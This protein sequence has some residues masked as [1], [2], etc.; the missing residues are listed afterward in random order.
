MNQWVRLLALIGLAACGIVILLLG[1]TRH[2]ADLTAPLNLVLFF[3]GVL[4]YLLPTGLAY[5]RDCKS[6]AWIATV[7]VLLGW[8][9]FGWFVA[10]GWAA[11]G[12]TREP[13]HQIGAPPNHPVPG[14]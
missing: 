11:S 12:K 8:T 9:I 1:F 13:G 2:D 3:G 5:Y 4:L 10:L 6:S 7:D 14:H